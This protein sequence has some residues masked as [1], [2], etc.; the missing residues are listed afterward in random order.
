[1]SAIMDERAGIRWVEEQLA[2]WGLDLAAAVAEQ[3]HLDLGHW[4]LWES[5]EDRLWDVTESVREVLASS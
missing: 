1:M 2:G 5:A 4:R 3:L